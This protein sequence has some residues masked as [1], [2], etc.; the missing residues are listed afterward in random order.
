MLQGKPKRAMRATTRFVVNSTVGVL[1]LFDGAAKM[2]LPRRDSD[3]GQ[4]FGYYGAGPGAYIYVPLMGP[5]NVR[6]GVGRALDIAT[7]PVGAVAGGVST[8][9]GKARL[10]VTILDA[11]ASADPAFHALRPADGSDDGFLDLPDFDA[12]PPDASAPAATS[13]P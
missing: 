4:T 1:G 13:N 2:N 3:F 11:R 7:D 9:F 8:D 5:M 10:G 12:P 6:D